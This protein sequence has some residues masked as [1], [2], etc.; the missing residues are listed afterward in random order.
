MSSIFDL[1]IKSDCSCSNSRGKGIK[2]DPV[3]IIIC[4]LCKKRSELKKTLR[5]GKTEKYFCSEEC[6][7]KWLSIKRNWFRY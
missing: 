7:S 1:F 3:T 6:W 4:D 5:I 2:L